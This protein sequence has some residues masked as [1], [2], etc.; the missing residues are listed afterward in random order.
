MEAPYRVA[1][2]FPFSHAVVRLYSM[3]SDTWTMALKSQQNYCSYTIS[4]IAC[5]AFLT[6]F[7]DRVI[8][9]SYSW[10][11]S[12]PALTWMRS[13]S[14]AFSYKLDWNVV[15]HTQ[16]TCMELHTPFTNMLYC[17]CKLYTYAQLLLFFVDVWHHQILIVTTW[18][19]S[20]MQVRSQ[21]YPDYYSDQCQL[22]QYS[23]TLTH[24]VKLLS[25]YQAP[26]LWHLTRY[27][28]CIV[29]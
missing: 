3:S 4:V 6:G 5:Q 1:L 27:T 9:V 11:H 24:V 15:V 21:S 16:E 23:T 8:T 14:W 26:S 7:L 22:G 28:I 17:L 12:Y 18:N 13:S 19:V 29:M 10:Q 20:H 25:M 2:G